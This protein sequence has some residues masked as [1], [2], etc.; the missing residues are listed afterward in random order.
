M[1]LN[2]EA[3]RELGVDPEAVGALFPGDPGGELAPATALRLQSEVIRLA[4]GDLPLEPLLA[5]IREGRLKQVP[6]VALVRAGEQVTGNVVAAGD[7]LA[8]AED[9]GLA[10]AADREGRHAEIRTLSRAMWR[11]LTPEEGARLANRA[12]ERLG[13]NPCTT[14]DL[15][16]AAETAVRI[17]E[18]GGDR[19]DALRLAG[20]ALAQGYTAPDLVELGRWVTTGRRGGDDMDAL[21]ADLAN[22]VDDG[23][24]AGAL[25]R[26]FQE[27]G[28]MGPA[29]GPGAGGRQGGGHQG[30]G[31]GSGGGT[32]GGQQGG[33]KKAP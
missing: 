23:L 15:V 1:Q 3:C 27:A 11:G 20:A 31:P 16:A 8:A 14:A 18:Q 25:N 28:W 21:L 29:D 10:A 32:G 30:D 33:G 6:D 9:L 24:A 4:R 2:L 13:G 17:R 12:R 26:Y 7:L 22:R 5:K 19:E